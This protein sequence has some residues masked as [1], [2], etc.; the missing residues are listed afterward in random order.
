MIPSD[1]RIFEFLPAAAFAVGPDGLIQAASRPARDTLDAQPGRSADTLDISTR[2]G[3]YDAVVAAARASTAPAVFRTLRGFDCREVRVAASAGGGT[4]WIV[5]DLSSREREVAAAAAEERLRTLGLLTGGLAHQIGNPLASISALVQLLQ[6][7]EGSD[8]AREKLAQVEKNVDRISEIIGRVLEFARPDAGDPKP[9]ALRPLVES[10]WALARLHGVTAK[11]AVAIEGDAVALAA[12][13]RI[14]IVLLA[15]LLNAAEAAPAGG[16]LAVRLR[17][18]GGA[19]VAEFADDGPG[20]DAASLARLFLPFYTSK[21][22][23]AGRGLSLAIARSLVE[24][25]GGRIEAA[26]APG[27]GTTFTVTLPSAP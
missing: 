22:E 4:V 26:S 17:S 20:L 13:D 16:R 19:A 24:R 3:G 8:D 25:Q 14:Q 11:L 6:M 7:R 12:R 21:G 23:G 18:E 15:L 5:E 1:A 9:H 10:T 2:L 27:K